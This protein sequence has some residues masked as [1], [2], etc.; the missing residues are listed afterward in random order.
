MKKMFSTMLI[1]VL[2]LSFPMVAS[3]APE[4]V[5]VHECGFCIH[6]YY[7]DKEFLISA[8][9]IEDERELIE[10]YVEN[11]DQI[12]KFYDSSEY[13]PNYRYSF[14]YANPIQQRILCPSCG[15]N[16]YQEYSEDL[17][18]GT[19]GKSCPV[20]P[21]L[22]LDYCLYYRHYTWS[23]CSTC[24]YETSKTYKGIRLLQIQCHVETWGDHIYWARPGQSWRNGWDMHED[25]STWGY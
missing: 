17:H 14:I 3:A 5:D 19:D 6:N 12:A 11:Q 8:I 22:V 9:D 20:A 21:D 16:T 1:L 18:W 25:M 13:D 15:Y 4:R 24:G 7:N 10:I 23:E 2:L